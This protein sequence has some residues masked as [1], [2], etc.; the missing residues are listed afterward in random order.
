MSQ[1]DCWARCGCSPFVDFRLVKNVAIVGRSAAVDKTG[2]C[3]PFLVISIV[4]ASGKC[5]TSGRCQIL[6]VQLFN[7]FLAT[8]N[9][10]ITGITN[11]PT[12]SL[13][14]DLRYFRSNLKFEGHEPNVTLLKGSGSCLSPFFPHY[15]QVIRLTLF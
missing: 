13:S 1:Y 12:N 10:G 9:L 2:Q 11:N 8:K 3:Y 15:P 5:L 6:D 4:K 14:P 7:N